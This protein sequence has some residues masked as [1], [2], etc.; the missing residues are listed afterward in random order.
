MLHSC[1]H[2]LSFPLFYAICIV[3]LLII[4]YF[5]YKSRKWQY[6]LVDYCYSVNALYVVHYFFFRDSA[7]LAQVL[8]AAANGPLAAAIVAWCN[9]LVFHSLDKTTSLIIHMFPALVSYC[10]RWSVMHLASSTT[11][12]DNPWMHCLPGVHPRLPAEHVAPCVRPD[13]SFGWSVHPTHTCDSA[14]HRS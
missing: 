12:F 7:A 14:L 11:A 3:P 13:C 2:P 6:F 9:S 1:R 4:R 10:Y 8:F 5:L